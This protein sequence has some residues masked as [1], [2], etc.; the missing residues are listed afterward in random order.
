MRKIPLRRRLFLLAVAGILPLAALSGF[1]LFA[2]IHQQRIQSERTGLDVARALATATDAEL[3]RSISVLEALATS[4]RLD[5]GDIEGFDVV[6][7]RVIAVR[8][9][10][11]AIFLTDPSGKLVMNAGDPDVDAELRIAQS[12][13]LAQVVRE[14]TPAVGDLSGDA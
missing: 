5:V 2:L 1:G 4:P 9:Q 11:R 3:R 14:R 7:R 10:W 13:S 8:S 6:A 12:D